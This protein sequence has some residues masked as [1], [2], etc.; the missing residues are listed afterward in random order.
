MATKTLK[1]D[2]FSKFLNSIKLIQDVCTDCDI[3]NGVIRQRTND[4]HAI[5][6]I[7]LSSVLDDS[8]LCFT[9]LKQKIA[10]LKSF[11]LDDSARVGDD[12]KD[13]TIELNEKTYK[14]IDVFSTLTFRIPIRKFLDNTF[15]SVEEV[16]NMFALREEDLVLSYN[17]SSY[18]C[19]RIKSITEG[20][21]TDVVVWKMKGFDA[22]LQTESSNK[23]NSSQLIKNISLNTEMDSMESKMISL[24]LCLDINSDVEINGYKIKDGKVL[25]C[26]FQMKYFDIPITIY[27]QSQLTK[28][29][30]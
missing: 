29:K 28:T 8:T 4:R 20:F 14:F 30:S 18:M 19:R 16:S 17:V 26:R 25:L 13:I 9:L 10:L 11:E 2:E 12:E 27:A 3:Q 23:D 5:V 22:S 6:E 1:R 15:V 24:P 21:N 7:D